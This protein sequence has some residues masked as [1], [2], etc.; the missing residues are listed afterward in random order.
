MTN[1]SPAVTMGLPV[2]NGENFVAEAIAC[3]RAQTYTDWELV[4][5]DNCS[6]DRTLSICRAFAEQDDRIRVYSNPRNLGVASNYNRVFEL[7]R[8]RYFRWVAH[9]DL[10]GAEF[11][12]RC[13]RVLETDDRAVLAF[14]QLV[15]VD[16]AGNPLRRQTAA[17]TI[18][19]VEATER[20]LHLMQLETSGEDIFWAQFGLIRRSAL[21]RTSVM[22]LYSGGDQ[23]LLL[24]LVAQ[25]TFAQIPED[26]FFRREHEQASTIRRGWSAKERAR[27]VWPDD[28]RILVFP[29]CR[30]LSEHL[31][32]VWRTALPVGSKVR[33]AAAIVKRF[34]HHWKQFA[35]ELLESPMDIWRE[36]EEATG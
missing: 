19:D 32:S 21:E 13:V 33:C 23:V 29:Y 28:R 5:S 24:E 15:H 4:I 6:T 26:L 34:S 18:D 22:G 2:Y 31:A 8:G 35:H 36:R 27:F 1:H 11:V 9:D 12:E 20:I 7:A 25:G 16:A 30:L 17:L 3:A 14:P 10:F